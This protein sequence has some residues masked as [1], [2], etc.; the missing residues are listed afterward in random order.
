MHGCRLS[1]V[2]SAPDG[3]HAE[4]SSCQLLATR[5]RRASRQRFQHL[6]R[7]LFVADVL[8]GLVSGALD[9]PWSRASSAPQTL[10]AG[11]RRRRRVADR[12]VPLRAVRAGG[13]AGVGERR[14]RG[15]AS[16]C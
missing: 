12:R 4:A 10:A 14:Q 15:A 5:L 2:G 6:R 13:P 3:R 7:L 1:H 8:A 9:R 11:R 16:S